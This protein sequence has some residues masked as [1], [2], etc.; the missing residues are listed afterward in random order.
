MSAAWCVAVRPRGEA[1]P[2]VMELMESSQAVAPARF[3]MHRVPSDV[4]KL[5]TQLLDVK[6]LGRIARTSSVLAAAAVSG[7]EARARERGPGLVLHAKRASGKPDWRK[8]C[9]KAISFYREQPPAPRR[10]KAVNDPESALRAAFETF[11]FTI[12]AFDGDP[13]DPA[14]TCLSAVQ[15]QLEVS[16]D[17]SVSVNACLPLSVERARIAFLRVLVSRP[18]TGDAAVLYSGAATG[19]ETSAGSARWFKKYKPPW[20]E[21][22]AVANAD[23]TDDD[24][25]VAVTGNGMIALVWKLMPGEDENDPAC[26]AYFKKRMNLDGAA[27]GETFMPLN[28]VLFRLEHLLVFD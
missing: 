27:G 25:E 7:F 23:E 13:S 15:A 17:K 11:T 18:K 2:T 16:S 22:D 12:E 3:K 4:L 8:L 5:I 10:L 26:G 6:E 24:D 9:R 1:R 28:E 20:I 21:L 19:D 14:T